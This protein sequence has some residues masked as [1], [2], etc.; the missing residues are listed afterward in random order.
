MAALL[1]QYE[2]SLQVEGLILQADEAVLVENR[3]HKKIPIIDEV[4]K[5]TA[6]PEGK[7]AAI[8]VALSGQSIRMLSNPYGIATLLQLNAEETRLVT[9]IAKSLIGKRSA[10]VIKTPN[11]NVQENVLPA[12]EIY[13]QGDKN[14]TINV[15]EGAEKILEALQNAGQVW[16]ISGQPNTNVGNMF[17]LSLIHI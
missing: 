12:G 1:N 2:S 3:I 9:P 8:E 7:L 13:I 16:D 14:Q 11:G 5:I 17:S 15:D 4:R 10:V 6:V